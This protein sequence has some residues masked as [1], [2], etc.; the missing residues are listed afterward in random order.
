[1][2]CEARVHLVLLFERDDFR[3][4]EPYVSPVT[5]PNHR[6]LQS[7][8]CDIQQIKESTQSAPFFIRRVERGVRRR[9]GYYAVGE[10]RSDWP[11]HRR[12]GSP[13]QVEPTTTLA[14]I[15]HPFHPFG[16]RTRINRRTNEGAGRPFKDRNVL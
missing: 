13:E 12:R 1:M 10:G 3:P 15:F 7:P 6:P 5:K 4:G 9:F 2:A 14:Q 8:V 11:W 16:S